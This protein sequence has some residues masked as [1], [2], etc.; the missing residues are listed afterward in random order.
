MSAARVRDSS[1]LLA[2]PDE[3]LILVARCALDAHLPSSL[4]LYQAS[5]NLRSRLVVIAELA[6]ERR[7]QWLPAASGK[8]VVSNEGCTVMPLSNRKYGVCCWAVARVLPTMGKSSWQVRV[9]SMNDEDALGIRIGVSDEAVQ[10]AWCVWLYNGNLQFESRVPQAPENGD[11]FYYKW[12][13]STATQLGF[14]SRH[15]KHV[16]AYERWRH[17]HTTGAVIEVLFDH[18]AGSLAFSVN[19]AD[20]CCAQGGFPK[21]AALRPWVMVADSHDQLSLVRPYL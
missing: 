7:L 2:L 6:G 4:S 19:G 14:P 3:L 11:G 1:C 10:R 12:G 13:E 21:G 18:D 9:N 17:D 16:M 8:V 15:N 20:P 5:A